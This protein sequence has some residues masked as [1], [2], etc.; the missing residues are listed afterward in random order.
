MC[1][2]VAVALVVIIAA[3]VVWQWDN[4]SAIYMGITYSDQK[5]ESKIGETKEKLGEKLEQE[6]VV[7]KKIPTAI[8]KPII[9]KLLKAFQKKMKKKLPVEK[10][11]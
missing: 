7:N 3:G 5:I 6:G 1:I 9:K 2:L 4:I 10:C 11:Q 8:I